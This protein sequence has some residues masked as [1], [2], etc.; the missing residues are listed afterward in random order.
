MDRRIGKRGMSKQK[1]NCAEIGTG[2]QQ[3]RDEAVRLF[4]VAPGERE[5]REGDAWLISRGYR[6]LHG[7]WAQVTNGGLRTARRQQKYPTKGEMT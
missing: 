5:Q 7:T 2:F 4:H 1:L 3:V 6:V